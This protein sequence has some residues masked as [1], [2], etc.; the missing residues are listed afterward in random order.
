MNKYL[1]S[2]AAALAGV[3]AAGAAFAA[4]LPARRGPVA[5]PIVYAPAFTWTGFYVGLNAGYSFSRNDAVTL[6]SAGFL[7][8]PAGTRPASL[9]TGKD[10]FTGGAQI[11]YNWQM[12]AAVFGIEADINYLDN[13]RATGFVGLPTGIVG[14]GTLTT[15]AGSDMTY[16][17]TVRGRLGFA[18]D[19]ALF[20]VTGGLA[21]GNPNNSG[22]VTS[23]AGGL[24]AGGGDSTRFGYTVGGGVEYA[25]TNQWTAKIEYLYYD[26][27]RQTVTA[28]P[29]NAAAVATGVNYAAR[30]ENTGHIVRGGINYKF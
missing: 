28:V 8:L 18:A 12:G 20:Y 7:A 10:G 3:M 24:W 23:T 6:G 13:K 2:G 5:A 22:L 19:R 4:D 14:V 1:V 11:G 29:L 30:F 26:L 17:G 25:L 16:L 15:S 21:Y 9:R 27:G